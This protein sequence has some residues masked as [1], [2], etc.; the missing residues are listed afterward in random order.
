MGDSCGRD[1]GDTLNSS[2]GR[3]WRMSL[4]SITGLGATAPDQIDRPGLSSSL[5]G[6]SSG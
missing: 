2:I 6:T 1:M 4:G 3:A 5:F